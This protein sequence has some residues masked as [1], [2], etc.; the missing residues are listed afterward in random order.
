MVPR[1]IY[2]RLRL[3]NADKRH[4]NGIANYINKMSDYCKSCAYNHKQR[5]G[6]DACPF[7]YFYW[8][9]LHRHREKLKTQGRMSFILKNLD[10]MSPEELD[11][12]QQQVQA[13]YTEHN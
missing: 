7:N 3:G 12:I 2:R 1:C 4:G 9:F 11:N 5:T 6:K 10:R 13:W 8:D